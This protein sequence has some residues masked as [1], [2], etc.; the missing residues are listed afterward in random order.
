MI[1]LYWRLFAGEEANEAMMNYILKVLQSKK[2]FENVKVLAKNINFKEYSS[3]TNSN[4]KT[5]F[6]DWH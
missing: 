2:G 3:T 5:K 6:S 1:G 4:S